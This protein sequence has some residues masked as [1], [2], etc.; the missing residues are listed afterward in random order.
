MLTLMITIIV[1]FTVLAV[2]IFIGVGLF[3]VALALSEPTAWREGP[4]LPYRG[5][6]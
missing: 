5:S 2:A 4:P 3:A 6:E 1:A